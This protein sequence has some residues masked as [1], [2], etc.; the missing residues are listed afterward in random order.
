MR[1]IDQFL[2]RK[3]KS[4]WERV[5]LFPLYLLSLPYG[6][7]VRTRSFLYSLQLLKTRTLP[8]PVISVG[9]ITVGGT[10]KTPL[11][12]ALAKGLAA[13][14]IPVAI[15][16]RGYKRTKT[17]EPVVSDGKTTFLSPEE[18]G[19]EPFLVAKA[20][21]GIPVLV[22]KDRFINGQLALQRFGV[23]GLLLD[24]GYQY[25]P[26][27]RDIN[28]LLIDSTIGFGD[29]HLLPRGILRE[30]LSHL[31][32]ADLLLINKAAEPAAY[33]PLEKKIQEIY[34]GAQVFH[35]DYVLV[36]LVGPEEQ[37]EGLDSLKG[38][39]VLAL[40]GVANPNSFSSM[41][42]KCEM[43]IVG[44]AIFP[45]HHLYTAKDL[46][47]IEEKAKEAG[48]IVTTEKDMVKLK[49]L[50]IG[51]LPIWALRIEMKIWEEEEFFKR[52]VSLFEKERRN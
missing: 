8:C 29:C 49:R 38:K 42:R 4:L 51:H 17:S 33:Q 32:R 31:R 28:I 16:S 3:K 14:G 44:E 45:D 27:Y 34:P 50:N 52:I 10:G 9:N 5:L 26:L 43:K 39:K 48:G 46:S 30:P 15:L 18:S 22:G 12:I 6:W 2:Y 20:C 11:V 36:S 13:R 23:R 25:L 24:D 19:D 7:G 41:L 35:R 1:R 21:Q 40:S 37:Q 47:Y